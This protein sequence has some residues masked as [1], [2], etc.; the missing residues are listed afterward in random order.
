ATVQLPTPVPTPIASSGSP[1]STASPAVA[2]AELVIRLVVCRDTCRATAGTTILGDGRVIWESPD[3]SGTV[4]QSSLTSEGLAKVRAAIAAR[5]EL[6]ASGDYRP[7]LRP[8][9]TPIAHGVSSFRFEVGEA[10][11]H[12][13]VTSWDPE[14]LADQRDQWKIPPEMDALGVLSGRLVDPLQWLG[15][16][17]F[18]GPPAQFSAN[19]FLVGIELFGGAGDAGDVPADADDVD[20][21]FGRPIETAGEPVAGVEGITTRCLRIDAEAAAD[22]RAAEKAAGARRPAAAWFSTIAYDW[23]RADGFVQVTVRQLLP[24][25]SGPC[26]DLLEPGF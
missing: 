1:S 4:L 3:D 19:G 2:E 7:V 15:V 14:S 26:S 17:A 25:E 9:A 5:P 22:L 16:A 13:L 24:H 6:D 23:H 8:G 11:A 12:I 10:G 20:W 21:P 18:A